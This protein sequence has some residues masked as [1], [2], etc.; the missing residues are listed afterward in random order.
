MTPKTRLLYRAQS[1]LCGLHD[2]VFMEDNCYFIIIFHDN[3]RKVWIYDIT[4]KDMF[5]SIFKIWKK[6]VKTKTR[7]KLLIIYG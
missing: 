3:I 2:S 5:F 1:D 6:G 4:F 7:L